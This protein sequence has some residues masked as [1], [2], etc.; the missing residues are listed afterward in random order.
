MSIVRKSINFYALFYIVLVPHLGSATLRTESDMALLAAN[1]VLRA[2]EGQE[3]P[4]PVYKL[5]AK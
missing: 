1:N 2:L 4:A 5:D 3:M